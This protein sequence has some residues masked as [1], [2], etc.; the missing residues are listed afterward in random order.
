METLEA[1]LILKALEEHGVRY[2]VF[3]GFAM[4]FHGISR[5]TNDLDLFIEPSEENISR[6]KKA[7][8]SLFKDPD[9]EQIKA[10]DLLGEYPAV[11]YLPPNSAFHLDLVTRLGEAFRFE[12]LQVQRIRAGSIDLTVVT[13]RTLFEMKKDTVRLKDRADAEMLREQFGLEP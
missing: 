12:D 8:H 2:A 6:L 11:Q 13:P 9:I 4:N 1:L 5:F 10:S 3:G 7:L